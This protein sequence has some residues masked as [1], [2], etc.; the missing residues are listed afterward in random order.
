M[1][2]DRIRVINFNKKRIIF[3]VITIFLLILPYT[4]ILNSNEE[5]C[6]NFK[7]DI[8]DSDLNV[9]FFSQRDGQWENDPIIDE[10]GVTQGTIL[11][12]G[13]AMTSTAMVLKYYGVNT[14]PKN[15]NAWLNQNDGYASGGLL[16]WEK[17]SEYAGAIVSWVDNSNDESWFFW[18]DQYQHWSIVKSELDDGYPVIVCVDANLNTPDLEENWVVVTGFNGG[19][20]TD[21]SNYNINDPWDNP[22]NPNKLLSHYY[23][24]TYDNTI[25]KIRMYHDSP[26][27]APNIPT[28]VYQLHL[29]ETTS[30]SEGGTINEDTVVFKATLTDPDDDNVYLEIELRQLYEGF[31][32][33]PTA[34]TISGPHSSGST[35]MITRSWLSDG[36]YHWQ[37]RARDTYGAYSSW[38][39]YGSN[40]NTDFIIDT[41]GSDHPNTELIKY[42]TGVINYNDFNFTWTGSDD[43]TLK[44]DLVYSYYLE[45]YDSDW[46]SWTINTHKYYDQL[47]NINYFFKV[48]AKD[49]DGNVDETPAETS[50]EIEVPE[51]RKTI[52]IGDILIHRSKNPLNNLLEFTHVGIYIGEGELAEARA[53]WEGGVGKYSIFDWDSPKD[54]Y[55]ALLRVTSA[56]YEVRIKAAKW[57]ENQANRDYASILNGYM[58]LTGKDSSPTKN[59]WYCSE[60]VWASYFHYDINLDDNESPVDMVTPDEI[61]ISDHTKIIDSHLDIRPDS[62]T[63][64]FLFIWG[65][66]PIDLIINGPLNCEINKEISEI[67]N[68]YYIENDFNKNGSKEDIV[69]IPYTNFGYYSIQIAA[70]PNASSLD[71]YT[72]KILLGS[73]IFKIAEDVNI[74]DIP[75]SPYHILINN[76][77]IELITINTSI[78][79]VLFLIALFGILIILIT[80]TIKKSSSK[81]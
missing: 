64:K 56:S 9:P 33:E 40:G 60:L 44:D 62:F 5:V 35:V 26:N 16:Y 54:K 6:V 23:D 42:P 53:P 45:G 52:Q 29:D 68:V 13:A 17:P 75:S 14:N 66:C 38:Q 81:R 71:T 46:S 27:N 65:L 41:S 59:T 80:G 73:Q 1:I 7:D 55:A 79:D 69:I 51:W 4:L 76:D 39:E 72:L 49:Q 36:N 47:D 57:A 63:E 78:Y 10:N 50:F 74:N 8:K 20:I 34:E 77:R 30:I 3:L 19:D 25:F 61:L 11:E 12:L 21:P 58:I 18:D 37:Y 2:L 15:L 70:E 67:D 32:G 31:S 48:K 22:Q 43:I 28:N 24:S